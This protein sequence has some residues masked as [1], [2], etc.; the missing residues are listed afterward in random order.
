M[1]NTR[2]ARI[3]KSNLLADLDATADEAFSA[4]GIMFGM[5]RAYGV[6]KRNDA[7]AAAADAAEAATIAVA[8]AVLTDAETSADALGDETETAGGCM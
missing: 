5:T 8:A 3:Q 7:A 2:N 4:G 1:P 6:V